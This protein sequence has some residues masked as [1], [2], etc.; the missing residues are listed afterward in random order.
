MT[1]DRPRSEVKDVKYDNVCQRLVITFNLR[2]APAK[3]SSSDTRFEQGL[4]SHS[5]CRDGH[6]VLAMTDSYFRARP[7]Y[8]SGFHHWKIEDAKRNEII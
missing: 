5:F 1:V 7:I 2:N 3:V 6:S 8:N 4:P